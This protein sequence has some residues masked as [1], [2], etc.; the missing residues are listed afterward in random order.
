MGKVCSV[1]SPLQERLSSRQKKQQE[2]PPP[3]PETQQSSS[4]QQLLIPEERPSTTITLEDNTESPAHQ[5][6]EI[7]EENPPPPPPRPQSSEQQSSPSEQPPPPQPK[8][9]DLA[10]QDPVPSSEQ[11]E[12]TKDAI[13][14]SQPDK[15]QEKPEALTGNESDAQIAKK[16]S[17]VIDQA[18]ERISPL[19][20]LMNEAMEKAEYDR[21]HDQ[22][23]EEALVKQVKPL[24]EQATN[25]LQ[26]THGAIKA[27]DPDGTIAQNASRK[28]QDHEASKEEQHLAESLAKLTGD[29]T[30]TI[31]NTRK[32]IANMPKAKSKL[33]PLLDILQDPLFQIVSG[34]GLLLNGVLSLLGNLLDGLGLGGIVR[35]VLSGLGLEKLL[36]GI[37][38]P[39]LFK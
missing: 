25:I 24:I 37:G 16:L 14:G 15:P 9:S 3:P 7:T 30:K 35:N 27:L 31:E 38:L 22:L 33:G 5:S 21:E 20:D 12:A 18:L 8:M 32:K 36:K 39:G 34:V 23:D 11:P 1:L 13:K 4:E 2:P 28:S 29:V 17:A 19:L 10:Q 26:E 6:Q